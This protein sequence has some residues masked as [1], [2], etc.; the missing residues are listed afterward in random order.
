MPNEQTAEPSTPTW[1]VTFDCVLLGNRSHDGSW[2]CIVTT[3]DRMGFGE[4]AAKVAERYNTDM[5]LAVEFLGY[6]PCPPGVIAGHLSARMPD[7]VEVSV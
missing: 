5:I 3:E 6:M 2:F 7:G 4:A 1:K